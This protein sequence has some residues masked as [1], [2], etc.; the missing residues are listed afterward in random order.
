MITLLLTLSLTFQSGAAPVVRVARVPAHAQVPEAVQPQSCAYA[1]W[2]DHDGTPEVSCMDAL[3][4][5]Q[6]NLWQQHCSLLR[7]VN[8]LRLTDER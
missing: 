3:L 4:F 7:T 1:G 8:P 5:A 6:I 2:S